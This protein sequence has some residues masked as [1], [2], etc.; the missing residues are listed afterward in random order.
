MSNLPVLF[1]RKDRDRNKLW[2]IIYIDDFLYFD[3][4]EKT[5][6][7]FE[8]E[9][10][11]RFNVEFQ[12]QAH[13]YLAARITQDKDLNIT[14]YQSRYSKSIVK[15][16]LETAGIKISAREITSILPTSF[17]PTKQDCSETLEEASRL[18][19]EYNIDYASCVGS[20]IYLVN[21]RPD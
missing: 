20:L 1:C 13:W 6:N 12:G 17:V 14:I 18:Q 2:I 8:L 16:Y 21:T 10:G 15:R 7:Q 4:S 5:R 3:T 9:F 11:S 19:E